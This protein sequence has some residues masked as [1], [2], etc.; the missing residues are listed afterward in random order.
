MNEVFDK[1]SWANRKQQ[2]RESAFAIVDD[3]LKKMSTDTNVFQTYLD[4]QSRFERYSVSNALLVASQKPEATN[5]ADANTWRGKGGF[6][7]KGQTGI[8]LME[9]GNSYT[10][11]DGSSAVSI[12]VKRVFDISQTTLFQPQEPAQNQDIRLL[13]NAMV[14]YAPCKVDFQDALPGDQ[15]A[16]YS[17]Q[18]KTVFVRRGQSMEDTFRGV[19]QELAHAYMDT[20]SYNWEANAFLARCVGNILCQ[21][22]GIDGKA[23]CVQQ[24]P[25]NYATM[26]AK[27][28]REELKTI[29]TAANQISADMFRFLEAKNNG[30]K[31]RDDAR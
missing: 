10:R 2:D 3:A 28:L 14:R 30:N 8:L 19:A 12:N 31:Q 17:P 21:R 29:R 25:Q 23:L 7:R 27:E 15:S 26:E 24:L 13:L 16:L 1:E 6:I 22:N 5:L 9:P 20:G 11:K 18:E 4:V